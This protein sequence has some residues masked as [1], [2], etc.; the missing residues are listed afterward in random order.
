[1]MRLSVDVCCRR[2]SL[3]VGNLKLLSSVSNNNFVVAKP[4]CAIALAAVSIHGT[5]YLLPM[6][7]HAGNATAVA[8]VLTGVLLADFEN[9]VATSKGEISIMQWVRICLVG[10]WWRATKSSRFHAR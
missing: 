8:F 7:P 6:P 10:L 1:M 2:P 4:T 5:P 3:V 9:H